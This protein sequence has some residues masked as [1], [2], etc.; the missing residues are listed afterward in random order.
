ME[1]S[2]AHNKEEDSV[3]EKARIKISKARQS[4]DKERKTIEKQWIVKNKVVIKISNTQ[5]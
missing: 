2:N 1:E 3:S 4:E 5:Y